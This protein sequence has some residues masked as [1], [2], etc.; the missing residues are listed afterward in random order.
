MPPQSLLL[1][2]THPSGR[3]ETSSPP[4]YPIPILPPPFTPNCLTELTQDS[5]TQQDW[6]ERAPGPRT[7]SQSTSHE[8]D[9]PG[10]AERS[11]R[12]TGLTIKKLVHYCEALQQKPE[13]RYPSPHGRVS[14]PSV[15]LAKLQG[16]RHGTSTQ[17]RSGKMGFYHCL[18]SRRTEGHEIGGHPFPNQAASINPDPNMAGHIQP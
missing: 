18:C 6:T 14:Q 3:Q 5:G 17:G 2:V 7:R 9:E 11:V 8:P 16:P 15:T 12:S 1:T 10:K 4:P 13:Y